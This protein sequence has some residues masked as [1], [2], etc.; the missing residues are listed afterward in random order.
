MSSRRTIA[1]TFLAAAVALLAPDA[2]A[3]IHGT[4][5]TRAGSDLIKISKPEATTCRLVY[6]WNRCNRNPGLLGEVQGHTYARCIK[7]SRNVAAGKGATHY[8]TQSSTFYGYACPNGTASEQAAARATSAGSAGDRAAAL[9]EME[10]LRYAALGFVPW[11][12]ACTE[13]EL[14]YPSY[15]EARHETAFARGEC[16]ASQEDIMRQGGHT[17]FVASVATEVVYDARNK[18]FRIDLLG[19][20]TRSGQAADH[21]YVSARSLRPGTNQSSL[22][23]LAGISSSFRSF[24]VKAGELPSPETF[25]KELV[26]EAL[27]IPTKVQRPTDDNP[28]DVQNLE[29]K[30]AAVRAFLP[31]LS[32]GKVVQKPPSKFEAYRCPPVGL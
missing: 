18:E 8:V 2:A 17:Y 6:E 29:V 16:V 24:T 13:L 5:L 15:C 32:W 21:R 12:G 3:Q 9:A 30:L 1:A 26:V 11:G 31:D 27:V 23:A 10:R 28:T 20:L 22:D 7:S 14:L 25:E 4:E 19:V